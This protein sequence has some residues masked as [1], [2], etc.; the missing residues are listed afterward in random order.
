MP[1]SRQ[2]KQVILDQLKDKVNK[3]K[4]IVFAQYDKLTVVNNEDLRKKLKAENSEYT[5]AKKTLFDL[6]LKEKNIAGLEAKSFEGKVAMVFGYEDEIAPAKI[7]NQFQKDHKTADGKNVIEFLG[8]VLEGKFLNAAEVTA[9]SKLP[10][11]TELYAK[12]VGSLNAPISGFVNV[13]AGNLRSL[14]YVLKAIEGKK[15]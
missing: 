13:L 2:Q 10:S 9:L 5:V 1:K 3:S 14:V 4:S 6:A 8:G 11:K 7:V 15:Q 12:I